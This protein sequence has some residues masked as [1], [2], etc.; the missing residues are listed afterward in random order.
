LLNHKKLKIVYFIGV[1]EG[2]GAVPSKN[3]FGVP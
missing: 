3:W 2:P 1:L